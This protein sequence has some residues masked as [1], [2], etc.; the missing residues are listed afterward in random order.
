MEQS[1]F[2]F[3]SAHLFVFF[4]NHRSRRR[5]FRKKKLAVWLCVRKNLVTHWHLITLKSFENSNFKLCKKSPREK[6]YG[7]L[8]NLTL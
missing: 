4:L 2:I 6:K 8:K 7:V 3:R 1:L 5:V